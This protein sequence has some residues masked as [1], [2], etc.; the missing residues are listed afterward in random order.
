MRERNG[1][2]E[3]IGKAM[4]T[5][6]KSGMAG[7]AILFLVN[8]VSAGV[9][10]SDGFDYPIGNRDNFNGWYTSLSL[11]N[12]WCTSN[13]ANCYYG[14]L[15]E[16]YLKNSG[17]FE[18]ETVYSVSNGIVYKIYTGSPN[19]WGGVVIIK[20]I[21]PIWNNF[22]IAGTT[23]PNSGEVSTNVVYTLYGHIN[24]T[25]IY[26]Y[27]NENVSRGAPIGKIGIVEDFPTSHLH[28]EIKNQTAIDTEWE[29]GVGHGYSGT[30]KSAP[31]HYKPSD[32]INANRPQTFPLIGDW[33]GNGIDST[34]TFDPRALIFSLK[35][36]TDEE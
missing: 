33:D 11:G 9:P 29:S 22:S 1:T 2:K 25:E 10:I 3:R 34:G 27:E 30:D 14:H 4:Q 16:D 12:S 35:N 23:L 6:A 7:L 13:G 28:F 20:H 19:S 31:N 15:G 32:F 17:S 8:I 26:V 5:M 21:S 24:L 18:D 36:E